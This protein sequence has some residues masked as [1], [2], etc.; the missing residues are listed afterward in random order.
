MDKGQIIALL[1]GSAAAAAL[2]SAG[3]TAWTNHL[4]RKARRAETL[5]NR[6]WTSQTGDLRLQ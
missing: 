2:I 5:L 3:M 4:E 6:R 1:F